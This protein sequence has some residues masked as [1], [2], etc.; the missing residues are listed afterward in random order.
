MPKRA[1]RADHFSVCSASVAPSSVNRDR[2]DDF[3][4]DCAQGGS[5]AR[6]PT[7]DNTDGEAMMASGPELPLNVVSDAEDDED[8]TGNDGTDGQ[9]AKR[10]KKEDLL[11]EEIH[12][13]TFI[14]YATVI[15]RA[16]K[17]QKKLN[18]ARV[19]EAAIQ[20]KIQALEQKG[21]VLQGNEETQKLLLLRNDLAFELGSRMIAKLEA[22]G[23]NCSR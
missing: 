15:E 6:D 2:L 23:F 9:A 12:T 4:T 8:H 21:S 17:T 14:D 18:K 7:P 22:S 13:K 16:N 20:A 1:V 11:H 5:R 19:E 10:L 3:L